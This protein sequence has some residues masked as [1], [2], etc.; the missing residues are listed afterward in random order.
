[1]KKFAMKYLLIYC[2]PGLWGETHDLHTYGYER[3]TVT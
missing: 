2:G 1:M 3:R